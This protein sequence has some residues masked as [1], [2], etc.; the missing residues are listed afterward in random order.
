MLQT[1][2]QTMAIFEVPWGGCSDGQKYRTS[3]AGDYSLSRSHAWLDE[4][5]ELWLWI[6]LYLSDFSSILIF[7]YFNCSKTPSKKLRMH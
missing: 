2:I 3:K 4:G 5:A 6:K 1:F 7:K